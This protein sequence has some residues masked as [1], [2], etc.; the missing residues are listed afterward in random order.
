M[1]SIFSFVLFVLL[2]DKAFAKQKKES[3]DHKELQEHK[4]LFL[5]NN[6]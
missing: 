1:R 3:T 5:R 2:W 6:L 4:G